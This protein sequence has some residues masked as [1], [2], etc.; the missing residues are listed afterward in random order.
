MYYYVKLCV[1]Q[2]ISTCYAYCGEVWE[3]TIN[4]L[5]VD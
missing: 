3:T 5:T 1:S 2:G 4:D